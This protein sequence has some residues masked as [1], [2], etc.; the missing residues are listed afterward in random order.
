MGSA[1]HR[2]SGPGRPGGY[3]VFRQVALIGPSHHLVAIPVA[4]MM[5]PLVPSIILTYLMLTIGPGTRYLW[6]VLSR[7][8]RLEA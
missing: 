5:T 4:G 1:G 3:E 6:A 2:L 8:R 7:A